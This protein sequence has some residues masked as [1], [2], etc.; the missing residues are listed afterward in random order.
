MS[1][2]SKHGHA[3]DGLDDVSTVNGLLP[4]INCLLRRQQK[5]SKKYV[6]ITALHDLLNSSVAIIF[7]FNAIQSLYQET[8]VKEKI[9]YN[10]IKK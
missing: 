5:R 6:K 1:V 2:N 4:E 9:K 7:L 3:F 10:K 8:S